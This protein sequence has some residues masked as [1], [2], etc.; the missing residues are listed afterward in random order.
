MREPA[1][2]TVSSYRSRESQKEQ[3]GLVHI[4]RQLK[5]NL[6]GQIQQRTTTSPF[7]ATSAFSA[8]VHGKNSHNKSHFDTVLKTASTYLLVQQVAKLFFFFALIFASVIHQ[9]SSQ[10][11]QGLLCWQHFYM[12]KLFGVNYGNFFFF[13]PR[14]QKMMHEIFCA[15]DRAARKAE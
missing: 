13:S 10:K 4:I 3:D 7:L 5:P 6:K 1:E 12:T 8:A 2:N 14:E 15:G 9:L 11:C